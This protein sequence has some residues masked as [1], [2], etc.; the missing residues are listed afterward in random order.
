LQLLDLLSL[1]I[2]KYRDLIESI[3]ERMK[4]G[5]IFMRQ[6]VR[7]TYPKRLSG[8]AFNQFIRR[9]ENLIGSERAEKDFRI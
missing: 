5:R 1:P 2:R 6:R 7:R 3:M 9:K 8:C 4:K